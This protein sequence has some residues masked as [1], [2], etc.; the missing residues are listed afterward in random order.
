MAQ[1]KKKRSIRWEAVGVLVLAACLVIGVP[2]WLIVRHQQQKAHEAEQQARKLKI[3]EVISSRDDY[4]NSINNASKPE[5]LEDDAF[6]QLK[7]LALDIGDYS[8]LDVIDLQSDISDSVMEQVNKLP[9]AGNKW[10]TLVKELNVI[11]AD[12]VNMAL[13]DDDRLDFVLAYP[14]QSDYQNAPETLTESLSEIPSLLQWDLR[15][16]YIPYGDLNIAFA[17]CAPTCLSMVLSYLNQ[18]PSIT[19][20]AVAEYADA[21]GLYV[22]GAGSSLEIFPAA[23][24]HYGD[25]CTSISPD[26]DSLV[27]AASQGH[28][29][30]L[31]MD[32]GDFTMTGHF[33][34]VT[35][36]K[37][38]KLVIHDPNS[39][40]RTK[41][42]WDPQIVASQCSGAWS[43]SRGD[44]AGQNGSASQDASV[45]DASSESEP[46]AS[47][48]SEDPAEN[49]EEVLTEG[50][51][52]QDPQADF[53][54]TAETEEVVEES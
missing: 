38:G 40:K 13:R 8:M 54:E 16:G 22:P 10:G 27:Q 4:V 30:I 37:D 48:Q 12:Y 33:I 29:L 44:G 15:W 35:G 23:A 7:T 26:A 3:A 34:V 11:P 39:I 49:P 2:A 24:A 32:P 18:D 25:S 6:S 53:A 41:E 42:L 45:S 36:V 14:K 31:R 20:A 51:D 43:F 50:L 28:P 19:P 9:A 47:G 21:S 1:K 17:G 52:A 5:D 46:D